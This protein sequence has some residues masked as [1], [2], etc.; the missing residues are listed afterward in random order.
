LKKINVH[1]ISYC[2]MLSALVFAL[3]FINI[4]LPLPGTGG[5]VHLGN[6]PV[7]VAAVVF[8][9]KHSAIA[10]AVG[11]TLFDLVG[12]YFVWA[13]FTL[14]IRLLS[15][16]IMGWFSEK[17]QGKSL[18]MNLIGILLSGV[19][20]IGG[21]YLAELALFG[22]AIVALTSIPGNLLQVAVAIA[23]GLPLAT[24]PKKFLRIQE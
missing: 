12:G 6:I 3:T 7:V 8:G 24:A 22:N 2:A 23:I 18:G 5:L 10:G 4:R 9:K 21:Y 14:I 20:L 16:F 15:G 1:T 11:M 13:P 17:K 19:I